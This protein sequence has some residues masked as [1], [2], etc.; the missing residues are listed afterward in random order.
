MKHFMLD[1]ETTGTDPEVNHILE[2]G[3]LEVEFGGNGLHNPGR[4]YQRTL[5][6]ANTPVNE[7]VK[8]NNSE[9]L[10]RCRKVPRCTA[11]RVRSEI[12]SFF[13]ECG[14]AGPAMIMGLNLHSLDIPFMLKHEYLDKSDLH[15]R[16][17]ELKGSFNTAQEV[18]MVDTKTLFKLAGEACPEIVPVGKPHEAL[19][20]C[21]N[22]LKTL[23]G[24]IRLLR[25]EARRAYT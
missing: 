18:L 25:N 1:I 16:T 14:V 12:Q 4:A 22:Q 13:T 17:Y 6:Y 24:V 23:N 19:F 8:A 21:Y 10:N 7:W 20:D 11:S 3:I 5:H 2:I 9:L 15:Y